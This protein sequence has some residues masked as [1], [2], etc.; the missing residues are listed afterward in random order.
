[1]E[2]VCINPNK[3]FIFVLYFD[4]KTKLQK[5]ESSNNTANRGFQKAYNMLPAGEQSKIRA[6]IMDTC[7]WNADSTF[8][9]KLNGSTPLRKL[10]REALKAIF[11]VW[12][13]DL[14]G[15]YIK[16]AV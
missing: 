14:S 1:M 6:K 11:Q 5:M 10:E 7:D 3:T 16:Q 2:K 9:A 13:I 15:N 4:N 12:N 8:Y